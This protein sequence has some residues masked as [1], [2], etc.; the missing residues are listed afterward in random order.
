MSADGSVRA[1]GPL[2]TLVQQG[3]PP[4]AWD[5]KEGKFSLVNER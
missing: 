5:H 1:T 2:D 3:T 4:I